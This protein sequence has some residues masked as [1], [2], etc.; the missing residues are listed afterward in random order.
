[1]TFAHCREMTL[2][3]TTSLSRLS[4]EVMQSTTPALH[5]PGNLTAHIM[6]SLPIKGI[7]II[8]VVRMITRGEG[9]VVTEVEVDSGGSQGTIMEVGRITGIREVTE[10]RMITKGIRRVTISGVRKI[11]GRNQVMV[12]GVRRIMGGDQEEGVVM[13]V[14]M[15]TG[16]NRSIEVV[17]TVVAVSGKVEVGG[18]GD[19]TSMRKVLSVMVVVGGSGTIPPMV[20]D[21]D[22]ETLTNVLM[23]TIVRAMITL[24]VEEGN[25]RGTLILGT[26]HATWTEETLIRM[27]VGLVEITEVV[28]VVDHALLG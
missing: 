23:A 22:L 8:T 21:R 20:G 12:S 3:V 2:W 17:V 9:V 4:K 10:V 24:K 19:R 7:R 5:Q 15:I 6:A 13:R 27:K 25:D 26:P 14:R 18:S 28:M 16:E 1:M 11:T